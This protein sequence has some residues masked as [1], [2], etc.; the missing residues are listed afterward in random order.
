MKVASSSLTPL[1][2][3]TRSD[4]TTSRIRDRH[5]KHLMILLPGQKGVNQAMTPNE[6]VVEL[7]NTYDK[8]LTDFQA[9]RYTR[10]LG[11][12]TLSDI[13]KIVEKAIEES[14]LL[15]RISV[16]NDAARDLLVL[17]PDRRRKAD[18]ECPTCRGTGWEYV[19]TYCKYTEQEEEAVKRCGC[20]DDP[21]PMG[22]VV[23]F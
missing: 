12:F 20:R 14:R 4:G 13:D 10:F 23:P 7:Q 8:Q 17:R 1:P 16:L 18:K 15:P 21:G 5:P 22:V 3:C 9:A 11:K 19:T 6:A 2:F